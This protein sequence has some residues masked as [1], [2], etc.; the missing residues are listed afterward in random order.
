MAEEEPVPESPGEEF[1]LPA[2]EAS[3]PGRK[4]KVVSL[5]R[6]PGPKSGL[7]QRQVK[8]G[9]ATKRWEPPDP[10]R[11]AERQRVIELTSPET[12][13]EEETGEASAERPAVSMS[14]DRVLPEAVVPEEQR[15]GQRRRRGRPHGEDAWTGQRTSLWWVLVGLGCVA[16]LAYSTWVATTSAGRGEPLA[17][18]PERN[19]LR[20]DIEGVPIADFVKSSAELL[21]VIRSL[22]ADLEGAEGE[23]L[24]GL[25]R[26][27]A[28][29]LQRQKE[30]RAS[31]AVAV[32][33][34]PVARC[35]LHAAAVGQTGYL[36]MTGLDKDYLPA[37]AYFVQEDG[38]YKFD[39][40]ASEGFSEVL[41]SGVG[42]LVDDEPRLMRVVLE[43]KFFYTV[44]FPE[45]SYR[46]YALHRHDEGEFIW[47]FA[48]RDSAV[49]RSM[50][51]CY[52]AAELVGLDRRATV[53]VR[54]GPE[55]ARQN[56]VQVVE[57]LHSD[58]LAP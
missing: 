21:P 8:V 1:T 39:W 6:E 55:G 54:K 25:L 56:E 24:A 9:G 7:V 36:L 38:K 14:S 51:K 32:R 45:K 22:L 31:R 16:V 2:R 44:Q 52:F 19:E 18:P 11:T 58:W 30:W 17:D 13:S 43:P 48:K 20:D 23:E 47:A 26:G 41:P 40:E 50:L 49:D 15:R 33:C 42:R 12:L 29:S 53:R 5:P 27:G 46:C 35:E 37:V 4:R 3:G 10:S 34:N 28:A 57:F